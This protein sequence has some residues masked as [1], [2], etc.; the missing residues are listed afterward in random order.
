MKTFIGLIFSSII[1]HSCATGQNGKYSIEKKHCV[2]DNKYSG[3]KLIIHYDND[4]T[5]KVS[6]TWDYGLEQFINLPDMEKLTIIGKLLDFENDIDTC[7]LRVV[8][9]GFNGIE[10]CRGVAKSKRFNLQIDALYMINRLAWPKM[11]ERYSCYTAL[12]DTLT[13]EEINNQPE[14]IKILF[15]DYRKWY[16]ERLAKGYIGKYFP[17]N[18]GRYAWFGQRKSEHPKD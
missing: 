12:V 7:C 8:S 16:N 5:H 9:R 10:G 6:D 1:L 11:I 4:T 14:K 3:S 15:Q 17:F 2:Y 18:D 13:H